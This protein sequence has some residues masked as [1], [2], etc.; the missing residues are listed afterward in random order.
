MNAVYKRS[1]KEFGAAV[2]GEIPEERT[3]VVSQECGLILREAVLHRGDET[4]SD[5]R[6]DEAEYANGRYIR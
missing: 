6:C 4:K 2:V 1:H 3:G 5:A